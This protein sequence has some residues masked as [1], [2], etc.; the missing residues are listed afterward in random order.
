[1]NF[2]DKAL[3]GAEEAAWFLDISPQ[4]LYRRVKEESGLPQPVYLPGCAY[5]KWKRKDLEALVDGL[6]TSDLSE[7]AAQ[8]IRKGTAP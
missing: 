3:L 5:A 2:S 7:V 6:G 8:S 1:M 4:T